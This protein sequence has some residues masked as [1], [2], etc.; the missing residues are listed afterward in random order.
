LQGFLVLEPQPWRSYKAAVNKAAR[1][2]NG[3][4]V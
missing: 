1:G 3:L 4:Q 2:Q